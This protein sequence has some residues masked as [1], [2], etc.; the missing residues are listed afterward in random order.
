MTPE[1]SQTS[2]IAGPEESIIIVSDIHLGAQGTHHDKFCEF[3]KWIKGFPQRTIRIPCKNEVDKS[4]DLTIDFAPLTKLILLGDIVDLWDPKDQDRNN[5]IQDA[6]EPF[7]ILHTIPCDKVY[8]TGNHDADVGGMFKKRNNFSWGNGSDFSIHRRHYPEPVTTYHK[9]K[10]RQVHHGLR[11]NR[12]HYTFLHGHQ[13]DGEQVPFIIS[14]ITGE[15]FDPIGTLMDLANMSMSKIM[16]ITSI[17]S[18]FILWVVFLILMYATFPYQALIQNA[19]VIILSIIV[20]VVLLS[21]FP[22]AR[23]VMDERK[24]RLWE[25]ALI[26]G[27][28]VLPFIAVIAYCA[29]FIMWPSLPTP[30]ALLLIPYTAILTIFTTISVLPRVIGFMQRKVYER[31]QSKDK[32]VI[33]VLDAGFVDIRDTI[34]ADIIIFG[35]THKAGFAFRDFT[36]KPGMDSG[37]SLSK[38]FVNTGCWVD[39]DKK[40][41]GR[42]LN[43][44]VYLN[45][46]GL[47]L[48]EWKGPQQIN[49]LFHSP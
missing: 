49:C 33:Q 46:I 26:E 45:K 34:K 9:G 48:L 8:V 41:D 29:A 20:S 6:L 30:A 4:H 38:L 12:T 1:S 17:F 39:P 31:F 36:R 2:P 37:R 13:F 22:A 5:V 15:P 42:P 28:F 27:I 14:E 23:R 32:D 19:A 43:T 10:K 11:I 25:R 40:D 18:I 7:S 35:H 44:F 24:P 47:Y 16:S 21:K 3:L